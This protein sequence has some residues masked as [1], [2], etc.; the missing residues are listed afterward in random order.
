MAVDTGVNLSRAC[1]CSFF[2][3]NDDAFYSEPNCTKDLYGNVTI[4]STCSYSFKWNFGVITANKHAI[5]K[6]LKW[7]DSDRPYGFI[8]FVL[9][10]APWSLFACRLWLR[11]CTGGTQQVWGAA[12]GLV[13]DPVPIGVGPDTAVS[14]PLPTLPPLPNLRK[15]FLSL[16]HLSQPQYP[17]Q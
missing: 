11:R 7:Y 10:W 12:R 2:D 17:N 5:S 3:V 4:L 9:Q 8:V 14:R 1:Y 6:P 15:C 13:V 16:T